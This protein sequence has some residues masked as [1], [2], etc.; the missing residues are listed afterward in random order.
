M[1][2]SNGKNAV[3]KVSIVDENGRVL[4]DTLVNPEV[5]I[6]YSLYKIHGIK[7]EWLK[8]APTMKKV[9][10]HIKKV[11]GECI[12]VGHSIKHDLQAMGLSGVRFADTQ[13]YEDMGTPEDVQFQ[14]KNPK[15]LKELTEIYLHAQIQETTH[16]SVSST[17]NLLCL[18]LNTSG[19][20]SMQELPW[21]CSS[22]VKSTWSHG[23]FS[24]MPHLKVSPLGEDADVPMSR[25]GTNTSSL[26][27]QL[28]DVQ[29]CA[30]RKG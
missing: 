27:L 18:T 12:F 19:R 20:L 5:P 9:Q 24:T 23:S 1:E 8:T 16:S 17:P 26:L 30:S 28:R 2:Q 11:V 14:R 10:E 15:K 29:T 21:P 4:I 25:S 7:S 22:H 3:C 13:F 6:T